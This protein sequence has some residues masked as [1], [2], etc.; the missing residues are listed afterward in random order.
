MNDIQ[1]EIRRLQNLR[2]NKKKD[3]SEIEKI[4]K[5]NIFKKQL[6]IENKFSKKED[7]ELAKHSF[8]NY[9]SNYT[10]DSFSDAQNVCDLI[11]EEIMLQKTQK[12]IDKILSDESNKYPPV[13][14]IDSLHTIQERIWDLKEKI[15]ISSDNK[16]TDL[17]ALE[18]LEEKLKVYIPFNRNEFSVVCKSCGEMLLLRRRVKD[19]ECLKH[20]AFSGRFLYNYEIIQDVKNGKITKEMGARYLRTSP[21]YIDWCIENEGIKITIPDVSDSDINSYLDANPNL[22]NSD[23]YKNKN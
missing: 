3:I 16:E 17:S 13:K 4:A 22:R 7:K 18:A 9:L 2:Q 19:F 12:D 15:G 10:I 20:P 1:N 14:Q 11:F 6:N 8:N 5:N 21:K 23:F